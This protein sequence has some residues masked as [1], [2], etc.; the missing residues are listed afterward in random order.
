MI[1]FGRVVAVDMGASSAKA[2]MGRATANAVA[3][4]GYARIPLPADY[5]SFDAIKDKDA[6][7]RAM[8]P[9]LADAGIKGGK[10]ILSISTSDII[11]RP[12]V[13][14]DM[15][16][17]SLRENIMYE[18]NQYVPVDTE[19]YAVDY[20]AVRETEGEGSAE[21]MYIIAA[22][23][24]RTLLQDAA[25]VVRRLGLSV[26]A[27]DLDFNALARFFAFIDRADGAAGSDAMVLDI[28]HE[29]TQV[30][31]YNADKIYINRIINHGSYDVDILIASALDSDP[32]DVSNRKYNPSPDNR[33]EVYDAIINVF[34]DVAAEAI[35]IMDYFNARYRG[36]TIERVYLSGGGAYISGICEYMGQALGMPVSLPESG[37]W[38]KL[39]HGGDSFNIPD[40][41]TALGLLLKGE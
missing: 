10:C 1:N 8:K 27:I 14:P 23:I 6:V 28:G 34:E 22:A 25:D 21:R 15:P 2:V 11:A 31:I 18:L 12:M 16:E 26:Y 35:R 33:H 9:A 41:A 39:R 30:I 40:F 36:H 7:V 5:K 19:R 37:Q 24:S 32:D 4:D 13:L 38:L 20:K 29:F 17:Q 3:V